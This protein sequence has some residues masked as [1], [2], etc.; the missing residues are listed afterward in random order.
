MAEDEPI[1]NADKDYEIKIHNVILDTVVE[2]IHHC[3]AA[4]AVLCADVSCMDPKRFP[5]IREKGLPNTAMKELSK[6][7]L[8]FDDHVTVDALQ[9]EL[10]SLAQHWERFKQSL[11]E[12]YNT[13]AATRVCEQKLFNL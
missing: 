12:E 1:A 6:C 5:E 10:T 11:Q 8:K 2:S 7:L 4:N 9:A 3:Y 13:R